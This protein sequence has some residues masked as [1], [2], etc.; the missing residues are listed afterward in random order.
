LLQA[1]ISIVV[2]GYVSIEN[3]QFLEN[4]NIYPNP[5]SGKFY[6]NFNSL[7]SDELQFSI[8]SASGKSVYTFNNEEVKIGDNNMQLDLNL[9]D[10]ATGYY[11]LKIE[12]Q[13]NNATLPVIYHKH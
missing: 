10:I 7:K 6:I 12:G 9:I 4:L 8:Y 5:T 3:I 1:T 2:A 11:F 13:N